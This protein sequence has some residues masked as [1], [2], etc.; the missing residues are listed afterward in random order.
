MTLGT[1]VVMR[2][3]LNKI[4]IFTVHSEDKG[5]GR[6]RG[7]RERDNKAH[8][9]LLSEIKEALLCVKR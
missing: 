2:P 9:F 3:Q 8:V 7:L 1:E 4:I 6:L 5:V